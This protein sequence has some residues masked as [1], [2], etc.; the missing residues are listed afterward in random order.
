ME[1]SAPHL[2]PESPAMEVPGTQKHPTALSVSVEGPCDTEK[3]PFLEILCDT[4]VQ[5]E[6]MELSVAAEVFQVCVRMCVCGCV[7]VH[8][9]VFYSK[10]RDA[11]MYLLGR[12]QKANKINQNRES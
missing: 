6:P 8:V 5:V 2:S 10:R 7:H 3:T 11:T 9:C 1:V 12:N 4:S